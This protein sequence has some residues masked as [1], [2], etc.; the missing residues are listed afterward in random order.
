MDPA[1]RRP[2][3]NN[4]EAA[5]ARP[6][7]WRRPLSNAETTTIEV[8]LTNRYGLH[9]RPAA[10][11]VET[12]NRFECDTIVVKDGME[13]NGKN[14]LDIMTLGAEPGSTLVIHATGADGA[15]AAKA[16]EELVTSNFGEE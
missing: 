8:K 5:G 10:M 12:C 13:V 2:R 9:A 1:A 6:G 15:E 14:I 3:P 7:P 16:L 4:A 11:F